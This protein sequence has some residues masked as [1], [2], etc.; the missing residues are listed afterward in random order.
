MPLLETD[1]LRSQQFLH[2]HIGSH[3]LQRAGVDVLR[4]DSQA[5]SPSPLSS[6]VT[7]RT[8]KLHSTGNITALGSWNTANAISL[9]ASQYTTGNPLW[10]GTVSLAP[11]VGVQYKFVK[12]GSSGSVTWEA[13]P[14]H[15]YSVPCAAATVSGSWQ[16]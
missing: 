9:S 11:G 5:V 10:S 3:N 13:D 14:N 2:R 7:H 16:S 12:V 15:T 6:E 8:D 4:R 1:N